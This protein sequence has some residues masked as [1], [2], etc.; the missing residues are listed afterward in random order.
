MTW[1]WMFWLRQYLGTA[2]KQ[3]GFGG[4][5]EMK[6]RVPVATAMFALN[7]SQAGPVTTVAVGFARRPAVAD[8]NAAVT[9]PTISAWLWECPA[10]SPARSRANVTSMQSRSPL[11]F[12]RARRGSRCCPRSRCRRG[13]S[14]TSRLPAN[15]TTVLQL[16]RDLNNQVRKHLGRQRQEKGSTNNPGDS[17]PGSAGGIFRAVCR[18]D[19]VD[20]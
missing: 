1:W 7:P 13:A 15:P 19:F 11:W 17:D 5:L 2:C 9:F 16:Y 12:S 8:P 3:L 14:D 18:Q 20:S 4:R 6:K 10:K